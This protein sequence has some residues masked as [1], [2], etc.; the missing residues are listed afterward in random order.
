M[1]SLETL[2]SFSEQQGRSKNSQELHTRDQQKHALIFEKYVLGF[3][4][5]LQH[6]IESAG[7]FLDTWL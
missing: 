4:Q 7:S 1:R 5:T 2:F 6:T 3:S